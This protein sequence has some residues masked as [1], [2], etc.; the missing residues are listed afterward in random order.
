MDET[1][2]IDTADGA[3]REI[4]R[5]EERIEA[6][7]EQL[8]R[9]RKLAFAA[10]AGIVAGAIWLAAI[11]LGLVFPDGLTLMTA[12][13][14]ILGGIVL[15]GSNAT[16]ANE[17]AAQITEAEAKRAALIGEI[18]LRLVPEQSRLLH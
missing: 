10:K 7:T 9:S 13:I 11:L 1:D 18:S 4:A 5:L 14:L 6:L 15:S 17:T 3:R 16:T 8:A 12:A 2:Q